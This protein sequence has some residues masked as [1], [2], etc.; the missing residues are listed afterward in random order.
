MPETKPPPLTHMLET[1]LYVKSMG[2]AREFYRTIFGLKPIIE[3]PAMTVFPMDEARSHVLLLF[4]LGTTAKD[5][6]DD[7]RPGNVIPGHGPSE[8]LLELLTEGKAEDEEGWSGLKQ[9]YCFAVNEIEEAKQWERYLIEKEVKMLGRM[10]WG[11]RGYS[12]YFADPD[13]NVGEVAS[14]RLWELL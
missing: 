7:S 2:K 12:V 9:H 4:E 5:K 8:K 11:K 13:G 1:V 10:D 3:A 6:P 14:K